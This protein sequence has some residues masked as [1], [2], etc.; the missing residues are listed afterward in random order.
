MIVVVV[1]FWFYF[2]T[3][4]YLIVVLLASN[5]IIKGFGNHGP[6][7]NATNLPT[8]GIAEMVGVGWRSAGGVAHQKP[9]GFGSWEGMAPYLHRGQFFG[10]V[11]R[12]S[13]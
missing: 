13:E 5:G 6:S 10:R 2:V 4:Y 9:V 3:Y 8:F 12:S 1:L 7:F 11:D